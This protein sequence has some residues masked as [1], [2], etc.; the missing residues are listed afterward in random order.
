MSQFT[1]RHSRRQ[2]LI[3][4]AAFVGG[5]AC[6]T[7]G[8][9][10]PEQEPADAGSSTLNQ[11]GGGQVDLDGGPSD[12]AT[13][14]DA[15]QQPDAATNGDAGPGQDPTA[16][17]ESM[18]FPLGVASGDVNTSRAMLWAQHLGFTTVRLKVWRM[19]GDQFAQVVADVEVPR[20]DG[21]FIH[22]DMDG[23]QAGQRY[24]YAFLET[25]QGQVVGRSPIGRFRAA[26]APDA[27]EPLNVGAVSCTKNGRDMATLERAGEQGDWDVFLL[28]GDTTY[29]DGASSVS[30]Y[31][32][33][34]AEN[35]ST[36][37][38]KKLRAA[39]SVLATWDDHEVDNDFNPENTNAQKVATARAVMLENL[40]IRPNQ[41]EPTRLWRRFTWGR[42]ADFF[43]LD[44]RGERRPSTRNTGAATYLSP[45]QLAWLTQ[46][47]T[48]STAMFKI[49][50]NSVP[51]GDFPPLFDLAGADR[52]EGYSS[53]RT[54]ILR[55]IDET[56]VTGVVW[57][58]G[59]FHLA[60]M[61]RV[62]ASGPGATQLEVLAG[63]GA[64]S[65]NP[66][67]NAL[68][69]P[70]WDWSSGTNNTTRLSLNPMTR[71]VTVTYV[72]GS[73]TNIAQRNY[74]V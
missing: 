69:A 72:D 21:N 67:A 44:C 40:P 74:T 49:I 6:V 10:S 18:F 4:S 5:A 26:I 12:A 30:Q 23:L 34:W 47:L 50:L 16:I 43:V 11:D 54:A 51:I 65:A 15:A 41:T 42:T 56:P 53:Q 38:Y 2:F 58:S 17:P 19:E 7:P 55:H 61:G 1:V 20:E 70:Q 27:L 59:D 36:N 33:R 48:E 62:S 8:N 37:G 52:W 39:T 13:A 64:Q 71:T 66:L 28:L 25:D 3:T 63:P 46:G 60:S 35:L 22:R 68:N 31:R 14:G 9:T 57:V 24:A 73:G 29:N 45:E 32:D